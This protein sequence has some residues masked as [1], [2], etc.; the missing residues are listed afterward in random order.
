MTTQKQLEAEQRQWEAD[1]KRLMDHGMSRLDAGMQLYNESR[2][3]NP[4]V[5]TQRSAAQPRSNRA[6]QQFED[7]IHRWHLSGMSRAKATAHCV[8]HH[9]ELHAGMLGEANQRKPEKQAASAKAKQQ[10]ES[11]ITDRMADGLTRSQAVRQLVK[12]QPELHKA[13]LA[14]VNRSK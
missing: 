10:V 3:K 6:T 8:K 1:L 14:E 9:P 7:A 11:F 4:S 2:R 12:E 13:W 5:T